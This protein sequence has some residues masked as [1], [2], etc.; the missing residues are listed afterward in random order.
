VPSRRT[1]S[2]T[3]RPSGLTLGRGFS[4]STLRAVRQ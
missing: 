2:T 4:S 1:R 3:A